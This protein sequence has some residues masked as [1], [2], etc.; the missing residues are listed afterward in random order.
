MVGD[1]QSGL[2]CETTEA[3]YRRGDLWIVQAG[4]AAPE[5]MTAQDGVGR[6]DVRFCHGESNRESTKEV[7]K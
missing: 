4:W 3:Q 2:G 6:L 1:P 5:S 7:T